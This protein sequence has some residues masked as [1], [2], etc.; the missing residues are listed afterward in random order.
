MTTGE[1]AGCS[2]WGRSLMWLAVVAALVATAACAPT[3]ATSATS[4]A[5]PAPAPAR[6]PATVTDRLDAAVAETMKTADIPGALLGIWSP[7]G[8]YVKAYG[9]ADRVT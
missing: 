6:L 5:T 4:A 7:Q 9:V 8:S 1:T 3:A 2:R